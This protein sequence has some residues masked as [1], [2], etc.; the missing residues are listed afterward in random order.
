VSFDLALETSS[1]V[2]SVALS[3]DGVV[4]EEQTYAHGL[5]HATALVPLIDQLLKHH[6]ATP[7]QIARV[8]ISIGP[9]SFTGLRVGVTF[10]KTF[11]MVCG[12]RLVA[13]PT[14]RV[15]AENAP[16]DASEVIIVLDAKR[17]QIFTSR[18]AR[19][20]SEWR[21]VEPA[22]LDTLRAMLARA[23]RPVLLLGEG[24]PYHR[25]A[26]GEGAGV[27]IAEE[28]TWRPRAS[29]VAKIGRQL[30][31]RG[32][33]TPASE[34]VPLYIRLPEAEEKRLIAE[35]KLR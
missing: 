18:F 30:A 14:V 24:I 20:G 29:T 4:L 25:D 27:V 13:V 31:E 22:R 7:K 32:I 15:L 1:R 2:G 23:G 21:E 34:L 8:F 17:G 10:A 5:Q 6:Q 33:W 12:A 11:A 19:D 9:G 28:S 3:R 35:G 16:P 26:I